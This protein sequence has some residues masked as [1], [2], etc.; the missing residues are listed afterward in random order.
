MLGCNVFRLAD[1]VGEVEERWRGG[2]AVRFLT[3][4]R[5]F[6]GLLSGGDRSAEEELPFA[7]PDGLQL[8]G[9]VEIK[10]DL[11]D[12]PRLGVEH[13]RGNVPPVDDAVLRRLGADDFR[14][15]RKYINV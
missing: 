4:H 5:F 8:A 7:L 15:R 11:P 12:W 13:Q 6:I 1:V 14:Q 10:L 2:H 3:L 9:A